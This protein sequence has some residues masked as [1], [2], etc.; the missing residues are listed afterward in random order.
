VA[1]LKGFG[2]GASGMHLRV[3]TRDA[4]GLST[5]FTWETRLRVAVLR[6][7]HWVLVVRDGVI[8]SRLFETRKK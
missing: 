1:Q 4:S 3:M 5:A 6:L 8:A 7:C 2:S